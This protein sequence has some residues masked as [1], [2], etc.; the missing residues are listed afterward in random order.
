MFMVI[1]ESKIEQGVVSEWQT[2]ESKQDAE[3][4]A[5]EL[6]SRGYGVAILGFK[7]GESVEKYRSMVGEQ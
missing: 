4:K 5:D 7:D 2:F 3:K 6:R 1:F